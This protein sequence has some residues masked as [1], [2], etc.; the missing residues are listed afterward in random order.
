M[1]I[2]GNGLEIPTLIVEVINQSD[3][4]IKWSD[5]LKNQI[6]ILDGKERKRK[7]LLTIA[8]GRGNVDPG[9]TTTL[10]TPLDTFFWLKTVKKGNCK[11]RNLRLKEGPHD[12]AISIFGS[13]SNTLSFYWTKEIVH[14]T[15]KCL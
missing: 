4:S 5:L 7:S 6:L 15:L 3:T 8:L 9:E 10:E 14:H 1:P 12:L 11:V 13:V 2:L